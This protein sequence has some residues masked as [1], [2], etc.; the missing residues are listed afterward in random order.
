[1]NLTKEII[2]KIRKDEAAISNITGSKK[3]DIV[4]LIESGLVEIH[5]TKEDG[6]LDYK[7][8]DLGKTA[9]RFMGMFLG[10]R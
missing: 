2:E 6:N 7:T 10:G 5:G 8:T 4:G 9:N 1:M 3:V